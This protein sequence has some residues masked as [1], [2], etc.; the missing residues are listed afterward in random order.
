VNQTLAQTAGDV[1]PALPGIG[2]P[3]AGI[4]P[5]GAIAPVPPGLV[6]PVPLPA[7][8]PGPF[9]GGFIGG[10]HQTVAVHLKKGDKAAKSLKEL[11]GT[12]SA[13]VLSEPTAIISATEI[14]KAAGKEFK[15]G[16]NGL[17]KIVEVSKDANGQVI[18]KVEMTP[19][20]DS[21]PANGPVNGPFIG[22]RP[23]LPK[24]A[25]PA[26]V[27]LPAPTAPPAAVPP[28]AAGGAAAGGGVAI[29]IAIAPGAIVVGPGFGF[30]GGGAGLSLQD[31]KGNA[32]TQVG[33][34]TQYIKGPAGLSLQYI[35]TFQPQKDQGDAAK[36]VYMGR[37]SV[38][39]EIPYTLKDVTLP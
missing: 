5:P 3:G 6:R 4:A 25:V 11:T 14:L 27:P 23:I 2:F 31:D 38:A 28:G 21:V 35:L 9:P 15:G 37:K 17:L 34:Q 29:G 39:V 7:P 26:P 36:L 33:M 10:L 30:N 18:V 24:G 8:F 19:P 32:F 1:A 22:P 13:H 20:T 16:E 12:V